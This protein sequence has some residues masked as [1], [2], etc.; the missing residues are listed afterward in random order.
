VIVGE[1]INHPI[2]LRSFNYWL[3]G[4]NIDELL[5]MHR[6][7]EQWARNRGCHRAIGNGRKGWARVMHGRWEKGPTTR[8]KW[9]DGVAPH[10]AR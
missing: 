9:L 1:I 2:G 10:E 4:G 8:I 7:I 3:Q 6:G 5:T